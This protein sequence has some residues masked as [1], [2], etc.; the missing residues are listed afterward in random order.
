VQDKLFRALVGAAAIE[1]NKRAF[2]A[3][4]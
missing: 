1:S 3:R 4:A 2:G